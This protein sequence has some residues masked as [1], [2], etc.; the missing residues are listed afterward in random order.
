[1]LLQDAAM[2]TVGCGPARAGNRPIPKST[3]D[4][5]SWHTAELAARA[6]PGAAVDRAATCLQASGQSTQEA[7]L[8]SCGHVS[9]E[10][11]VSSVLRFLGGSR[12]KC[13]RNPT[14]TN[15]VPAPVE[16]ASSERISQEWASDS[17]GSSSL[18]QT[19]KRI[20]CSRAGI[21]R[22]HP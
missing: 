11:A 4:A 14:N 6:N 16:G 17:V 12:R 10:Y 1:M 21:D 22:P 20:R 13:C 3:V 19:E 15:G 2:L 8:R 7:G 9:D 5:G 18:R